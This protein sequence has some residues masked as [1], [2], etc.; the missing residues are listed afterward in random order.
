MPRRPKPYKYRGWY[1]TDAGGV[2]HH[3]LSP[4][5]LGMV[6]AE[7]ELRKYLT[8]MDE[9]RTRAPTR[10]PYKDTRRCL[11]RQPGDF[12]LVPCRNPCDPRANN[13]ARRC[14]KPPIP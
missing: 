9:A 7:R 1:V 6:E 11:F 10:G 13:P 3:K 4:V 5:E 12:P 8:R 14:P 2:P